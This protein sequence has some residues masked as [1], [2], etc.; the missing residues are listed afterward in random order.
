[1]GLSRGADC[2]RSR[3]YTQSPFHFQPT[4]FTV[5]RRSFLLLFFFSRLLLL[6]LVEFGSK[7]KRET[8]PPESHQLLLQDIVLASSL[9]KQKWW[10]VSSMRIKSKLPMSYFLYKC[11]NTLTTEYSNVG[12]FSRLP[13]MDFLGTL[14]LLPSLLT[15]SRY[16]LQLLGC[17]KVE[18]NEKGKGAL[19]CSSTD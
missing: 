8:H 3:P 13:S 7:R 4:Q 19:L 6:L 9:I 5:G 18:T 11:C 1:M 15:E 10:I 14:S 16:V 12:P 17:Q 2:A